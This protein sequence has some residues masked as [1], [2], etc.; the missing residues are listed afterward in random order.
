[1][2][3]LIEKLLNENIN[4][5]SNITTIINQPCKVLSE[6]D[7]ADNVYQKQIQYDFSKFTQLITLTIGVTN[8]NIFNVI[9]EVENRLNAKIKVH[10]IR[11]SANNLTEL[12]D[13][14]GKLNKDIRNINENC[15]II[16]NLN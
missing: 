16:K 14:M 10:T 11:Y 1:M 3:K 4:L 8:E 6:I 15:L 9:L 12:K 5:N 7:G 13:I 2:N